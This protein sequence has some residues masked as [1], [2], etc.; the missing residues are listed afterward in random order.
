MYWY[1]IYSKQNS[2]GQ[3]LDILNKQSDLYAFVPKIEKWFKCKDFARY[4]LKDMYPGY[5]FIKS[6]LDEKSFKSKYEEMLKSIHRLAQLLEQ[7]DFISL[8]NDEIQLLSLFLNN[9]DI[10]VHSKGKYDGDDLKIM[11]GPLCGLESKIKKINRHKHIA[12]VDCH[13]LGMDMVLPLEVINRK[14]SVLS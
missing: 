5:I 13:L 7:D 11:Y 3:L 6:S 1:I 14:G 2:Y 10:I 8:K 4:E 12:K 9:Q